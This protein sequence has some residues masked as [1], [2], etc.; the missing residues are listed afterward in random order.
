MKTKYLNFLKNVFMASMA[1]CLLLTS[2][3]DDDKDNDSAAD[4]S[5]ETAKYVL[6]TSVVGADMTSMAWYAQQFDLSTASETINN[7]NA[8]EID[9]ATNS[10]PFAYGSNIFFN[11][12]MNG[13]LEKWSL[14]SSGNMTKSGELSLIEL[15]YPGNPCFYKEDVAFI[16]GPGLS[17]IVIFNPKTLTKTGYIDF[18]SVA[19]TGQ[20]TDF[21]VAG[22]KIGSEAV[23]EMIVSGNYLYIALQ[24]NAAGYQGHVPALKACDIIVVDLTKVSTTS[25]DNSSA[26]V[27]RL[28]DPR[29]SST[30][31]WAAGGGASY[32]IKDENNDVYMLCHNA[33]GGERARIGLPACVLRIKSG[34]TEFDQSYYFDVEAASTGY[35]VIGLEYSG[36][37]KF[38]AAVLDPS[39][40]DPNN[41]WSYYLDPIYRWYQF[42]LNSKTSVIVS[43]ILTKGSEA[44]N[45]YF[46]DGYAYLPFATKTETYISKVNLNTLEVS[47]LFNTNGDPCIFKLY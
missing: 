13:K 30:G 14:N 16:G 6:T 5:T 11:K 9:A 40:V 35:P 47:K 17:K 22:D 25:T 41:A 38:F 2:C 12:Y 46:E 21:P 42:D 45:T 20:Q 24:C 31:A 10:V 32:M 7:S 8:S 19:K 27:K 28:S 33:W 26:I 36:N 23:T 37:G 39:A 29:G 34:Q 43:D 18:K 3:S 1:I 44:T 4:N 15:T